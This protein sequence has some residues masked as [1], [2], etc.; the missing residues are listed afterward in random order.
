ML[1]ML[2]EI[3]R[4]FN[5]IIA[6]SQG[7]VTPPRRPIKSTYWE[8]EMTAPNL[9]PPSLTKG[10]YPL[11]VGTDSVRLSFVTTGNRREANDEQTES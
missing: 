11:T 8:A 2:Q 5:V 1:R 4:Q 6:R 3:E 9:T 7:R 10:N